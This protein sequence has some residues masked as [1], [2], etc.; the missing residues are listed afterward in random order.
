MM[1]AKAKQLQMSRCVIC[2]S[3]FVINSSFVIRISSFLNE[4]CCL[5]ASPTLEQSKSESERSS[6]TISARL[7]VPA[8]PPHPLSLARA[9]ARLHDA[10]ACYAGT[11]LCRGRV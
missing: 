7:Q 1:N 10:C 8:E 11:A 2:H 5:A 4:Y 9:Q 6:R 3:S